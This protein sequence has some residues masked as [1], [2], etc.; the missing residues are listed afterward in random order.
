MY[1]HTVVVGCGGN[2]QGRVQEGSEEGD[3]LVREQREEDRIRGA[4]RTV[5]VGYT[6]KG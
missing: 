6:T 2:E 3:G 5:V 1:S 4:S